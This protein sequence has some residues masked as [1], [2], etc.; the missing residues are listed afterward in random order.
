MRAD[1]GRVQVVEGWVAGRVVVGAAGGGGGGADA[2]DAGGG[3]FR[4]GVV[5]HVEAPEQLVGALVASGV[6]PFVWV[7]LE[8]FE[9]FDYQGGGGGAAAGAAGL[10]AACQAARAFRF[11]FVAVALFG[12]GTGAQGDFFAPE[13]VGAEG[14]RVSV[15]FG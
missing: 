9:G 3:V 7:W 11:G 1:D 6:P 15:E 2:G 8:A 10:A 12:R 4:G 13:G 14:E 5:G